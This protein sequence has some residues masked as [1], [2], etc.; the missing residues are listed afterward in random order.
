MVADGCATLRI[1]LITIAR[2]AARRARGCLLVLQYDFPRSWGCR[3]A[4]TFLIC[5]ARGLGNFGGCSCRLVFAEL[6]SPR[7]ALPRSRVGLRVRL[8]V[9]SVMMFVRPEGLNG[10]PVVT[11]YLGGIAGAVLVPC[12]RLLTSPTTAP[13]GRHPESVVRLHPPVDHGR[14]AWLARHGVHGIG[15]YVTALAWNH[16]GL[17]PDRHPF[18]LVRAASLALLRLSVIRFHASPPLLRAGHPRL[19]GSCCM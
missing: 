8:R 19:S 17:S 5:R 4:I 18:A 9:L 12:R 13:P 2:G 14:F 15:A 16:G 7:R 10:A 3:R 1:Y 6:I 11:R